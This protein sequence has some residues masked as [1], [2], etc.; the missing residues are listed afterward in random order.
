MQIREDIQT[1]MKDLKEWLDTQKDVRLEEMGA[2]FAAR[3][4]D[5]EEHMAIWTPAYQR[6]SQ[7]VPQT[8]ENILDLGCGTGLELDWLWQKMPH[9][10]VTGVDLCRDMLEK[11]EKKHPDKQLTTVCEDYFHYDMGSMKWDAVISF[12]SLH[13]FLPDKKLGLYRT[14]YESLRPGAPFLLGDYVACCEEEEELL[15]QVWRDKRRQ[16]GIPEEQFVHFDI[17]LTLEKEISLLGQAG[18]ARCEAVDCIRGAAILRC[19]RE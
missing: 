17:P 11:L 2:F 8:C 7:L 16:A 18:F 3:L 4:G 14:I 1:Y 6:F 13:H 9:L 10:A 15:R 12:E 19:W 5:Y